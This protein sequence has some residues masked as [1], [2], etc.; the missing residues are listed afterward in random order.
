MYPFDAYYQ[1]LHFSE[2]YA[3]YTQGERASASIDSIL[4]F[5]TACIKTMIDSFDVG[6]VF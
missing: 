4:N 1:Y 5:G 2:L 6:F 3:S